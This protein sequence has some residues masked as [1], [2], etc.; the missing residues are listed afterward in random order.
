ML[1]DTAT[2]PGDL[3]TRDL[4]DQ[5]ATLAAH[6]SAAEYRFLCLVAELERRRAWA[7]HGVRSAAHWLA[8][9]CGIGL[10]AA[11]E[12]VRVAT[13]LAGLPRISQV[14]AEGRLS[15]SKVRA[16]TRIAAPH[17]EEWLLNLA[18]TGT[19]IHV[20]RLVRIARRFGPDAALEAAQRAEAARRVTWRWD[21]DGSLVLVAR[22]PPDLGAL[23][24]KA[25]DA[26]TA[27]PPTPPANTDDVTAVTPT[28]ETS[29]HARRADAL[30]TVAETFLASGPR[31]G[32]G[33]ERHQVQVIVEVG[34]AHGQ[35]QA[36][37]DGGPAIALDTARRLACDCS[38]V[39][40]AERPGRDV[41]DVGRRTRSIPPAIAR[42]L[43]RR[44][45]GC[46]FPGCSNERFVDGHHVHHWA[47]GGKTS[48]DNLV[49]LCRHHHRLVHEGGFTVTADGRGGWRFARPDGVPLPE[50]HPTPA[51]DP[52]ALIASH[53]RLGLSPL[54]LRPRWRGER[55]DDSM[56]LDALW[57]LA[58]RAG[59]SV[60][61]RSLG[62]RQA[63]QAPAA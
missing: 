40:L 48:L 10:N 15:F 63:G 49:L 21:H 42:A 4:E 39:T 14:F 17:S 16:L 33:A 5:I 57:S 36:H 54:S 18:L 20:E 62:A 60:R 24:I 11:R 30:A 22:L 12:K 3:S 41:L 55:M 2:P 44:D 56:A 28:P 46:R 35:A 37:I 61:P 25:L 47:D 32:S 34:A 43:R 31:E 45:G 38:V 53:L 59:L 1:Q 7:V 13:A 50:A 27:P 9:R 52:E 6:I 51:G 26:A 8:W 23:V 58:R 19:A 29:L